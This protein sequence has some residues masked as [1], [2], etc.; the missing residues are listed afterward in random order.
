LHYSQI[1]LPLHLILQLIVGT[2]RIGNA[3]MQQIVNQNKLGL[4]NRFHIAVSMIRFVSVKFFNTMKTRDFFPS[5]KP[6]KVALF[7]IMSFYLGYKSNAQQYVDLLKIEYNYTAPTQFD[8]SASQSTFNEFVVDF[9][10]PIQLNE[11]ISLLTGFNWERVNVSPYPDSLLIVHGTLIKIGINQK[12]SGN[13]STT[14]LFLPKFSSDLVKISKDDFQTGLWFLMKNEISKNKNFRFGAYINRELFGPLVVP[15]FG[16][17]HQNNKME[18][19]LTLPLLADINYS[20][21]SFAKVGAKFNGIVKSYHLNGRS[22]D[23]IVKANNEL[24]AYLQ[25]AKGP[26][27]FQIVAG[28]SIGRSIR[29]YGENER[30]V[31]AISALKIGDNRVQQNIDFNDGLF[32]KSSIFY[33][34]KR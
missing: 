32:I 34:F 13:W 24:G 5:Y 25:F 21:N 10:F 30:I 15:L 6:M 12:L 29:T 17:Y 4:V 9:T 18:V 31:M 14:L 26:V 27:N 19:N 8:N 1:L 23:Y 7:L 20:L 28:T 3:A 16:F 22:V 11:K 33:R 2:I